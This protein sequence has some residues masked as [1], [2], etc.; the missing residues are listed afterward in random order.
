[1]PCIFC[2]EPQ[3]TNCHVLPEWLKNATVKPLSMA[4]RRVGVPLT[5]QREPSL[6]S[7]K[8]RVAC[9]D[10]CNG[11]WMGRLEDAAK[12]IVTPLMQ[13]QRFVLRPQG[14]AILARW[15][16]MVALLACHLQPKIPTPLDYPALFYYYREPPIITAVWIASYDLSGGRAESYLRSGLAIPWRN[17]K[18]LLRPP[19]A[20]TPHDINGYRVTVNVWHLAFMVVVVEPPAG[21]TQRPQMPLRIDF[22]RE[23]AGAVPIWP[24]PQPEGVMWPIDP[25]I[26]DL[27]LSSLANAQP[28]ITPYR[29]S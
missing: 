28:V 16:S 13:N 18:P 12:D 9:Q 15:T 7:R 1:M 24:S 3:V 27:G 6:Y 14:Q 5:G 20:V 11:G 19:W 21:W 22:D 4:E 10:R 23:V 2:G 17:Y 29:H 8:V 25:P 26:D